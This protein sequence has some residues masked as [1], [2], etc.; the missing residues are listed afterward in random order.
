MMAESATGA[1]PGALPARERRA[2]G[3][4]AVLAAGIGVWLVVGGGRGGL[5][6][7]VLMVVAALALAGAA[8]GGGGERPATEA[9]V[10]LSSRIGLGLLGG[11][12]AGLAHGLLTR[13]GG[14]SGLVRALDVSVATELT[15]AQWLERGAIGLALGVAFGLVYPRLPGR[16]AVGRAA[17]FSLL[18]S[19]YVLLVHYPLRE[20]F[21]LLGVGLGRFTPVLVLTAN[22][23]AS[24]VA[25]GALRW[26]ERTEG[27]PSRALAE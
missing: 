13:L 4:G 1:G 5:T 7:G 24:L 8:I 21:G 15:G 10:D 12:L 23:A 16:S 2:A 6:A 22:L 9:G 17:A 14:A 3:V 26:A 27:T 18:P 19:L 25:A 20:Q 11:G